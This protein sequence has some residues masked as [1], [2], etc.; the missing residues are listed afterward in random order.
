MNSSG[1]R[2]GLML[3]DDEAGAHVRGYH[4]LTLLTELLLLWRLDS[5]KYPEIAYLAGQINL[6][7]QLSGVS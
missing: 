3:N 4:D 2:P 7:P 1:L 5:T 6:T